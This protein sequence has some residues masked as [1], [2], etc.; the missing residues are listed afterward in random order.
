MFANDKYHLCWVVRAGR[1]AAA[2][3]HGTMR[4]AT[5]ARDLGRSPA[6]VALRWSVQQGVAVIA[7]TGSP[8]HMASDLDLW[9]FELSEDEMAKISAI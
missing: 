7:G 9:S 5:H 1:R 3:W 8:T 4:H 2:R 6:Q